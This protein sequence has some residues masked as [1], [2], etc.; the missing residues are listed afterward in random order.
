MGNYNKCNDQNK[1]FQTSEIFVFAAGLFRAAISQSGS[2]LVPW[3]FRP[4][5]EVKRMVV[6]LAK[7]SG[8]PATSE[9]FADCLRVMSAKQL[10]D[11]YY[12]Y[13]AWT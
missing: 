12:S 5:I 6:S 9:E 8:C 1:K 3:P 11:L 13:K 2:A 10:D 4:P 7:L